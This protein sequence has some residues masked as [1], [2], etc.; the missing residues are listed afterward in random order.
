M[1]RATCAAS[2]KATSPTSRLLPSGP[3]TRW[4]PTSM[5]MAPGLIQLPLHHLRP[6]DGGHHQV[7]A[8]H[9]GGQIAGA[10]VGDGHRA[11]LVEQQLR[12]RLA[13]DVGAA[14]HH[15][16]EPREPRLDRLGQDQAAGR[17]ARR[18]RLGAAG[19]PAD[20]DGVE[21][22][23][24]LGR[25]DRLDDLARVDVR[26]AAAA[27]PGCRARPGG[28]RARRSAPAAPPRACR[29]AACARRT[30]CRPRASPWPWCAR[31]PGL[32]GPRRPARRR[33]RGS[34]RAPAAAPPPPRPPRAAA[35]RRWP[36]RR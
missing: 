3:A 10:R 1:A 9:H 32:R 36:C 18:Q 8:A 28:G 14:D 25:V 11:M 22:V 31:R 23:D 6:A 24:V 30:A 20:V 33:A 15:R 4:M 2:A 13:D 7:G 35:P 12:H 19:Q 29:P 5:T 27:A 17:R 21:A 26:R 34:A 16:L